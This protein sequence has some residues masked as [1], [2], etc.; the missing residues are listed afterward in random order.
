MEVEY[1]DSL[2]HNHDQVH[3][4]DEHTHDACEEGVLP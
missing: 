2:Q 1:H 3:E 4:R